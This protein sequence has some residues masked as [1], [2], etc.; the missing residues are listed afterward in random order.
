MC[1]C[2]FGQAVTQALGSGCCGS[3][4][5]ALQRTH[6]QHVSPRNTRNI[7]GSADI[8]QCMKPHAPNAPRWDYAVGYCDDHNCRKVFFIEVHPYKIGELLEKKE[9]LEKFLRGQGK[10]LWNWASNREYY[11]V[12][13]NSA[14]RAGSPAHRRLSS[15][16]FH[17]ASQVGLQ[18]P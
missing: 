7:A 17:V 10:P 13:T 16:G 9:W 2:N 6:R 14:P 15:L 8:D 5:R 18:C 3:G 4:L 12:P 1:Q 11:W